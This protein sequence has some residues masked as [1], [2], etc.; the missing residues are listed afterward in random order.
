M[1]YRLLCGLWPSLSRCEE[2]ITAHIPASAAVRRSRRWPCAVVPVEAGEGLEV[3]PRVARQRPLREVGDARAAA[4]S[5]AHLVP[6]EPEV[7]GDLG[8]T[9]NWHVA[10]RITLTPSGW[11]HGE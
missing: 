3:R 7:R 8:A 10:T 2:P 6:G 4:A 11:H 9:G 1:T 5:P